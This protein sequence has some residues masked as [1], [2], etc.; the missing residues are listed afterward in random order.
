MVEAGPDP[1]I[2]PLCR[3]R[4]GWGATVTPV[5]SVEFMAQRPATFVSS[6]E[7]SC[8]RCRSPCR[9]GELRQAGRT[10]F[11]PCEGQ[12]RVRKRQ[13]D[14]DRRCRSRSDI[15]AAPEIAPRQ[16]ISRPDEVLRPERYSPL[17]AETILTDMKPGR[18]GSVLRTTNARL[19]G[20]MPIRKVCG[21]IDPRARELLVGVS[22][23]GG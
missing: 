22:L 16:A 23:D 14:A 17:R 4:G 1:K 5:A 12:K 7:N 21:L 11:W 3:V 8:T 6:R 19:L 15:L 9:F 2:A 10:L 13:A 20:A 18:F